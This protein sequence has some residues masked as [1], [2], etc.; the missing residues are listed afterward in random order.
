LLLKANGDKYEIDSFGYEAERV[1]ITMSK[2]NEIAKK[3]FG[4][5]HEDTIYK[6][7][8]LFK[9]FK[10]LLYLDVSHTSSNLNQL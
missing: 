6:K 7:W 5:D 3:K 4:K 1:Y 8:C 9:R 10:H 2:E